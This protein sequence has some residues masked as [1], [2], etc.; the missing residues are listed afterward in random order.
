MGYNRKITVSLKEN[1][2]VGNNLVKQVNC[3][4]SSK[5]SVNA[6]FFDRILIGDK[7]EIK[8][9]RNIVGFRVET[10]TWGQEAPSSE[11][12]MAKQEYLKGEKE[13]AFKRW[14]SL[15]VLG[16]GKAMYQVGLSYLY[17]DGVEKS[18][19]EAD[20][21]LKSA[22]EKGFRILRSLRTSSPG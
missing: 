17:G 14:Q 9:K 2:L 19:D 15:A 4:L 22:E 18:V 5:Y 11:Y 21:W 7:T 1:D 3:F 6:I 16:D 10:I 12:E 20:Y 8:G 13:N